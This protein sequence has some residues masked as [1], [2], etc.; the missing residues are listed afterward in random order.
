MSEVQTVPGE[1]Q[2]ALTGDQIRSAFLR[3]FEQRGH[4]VVP[5][6]S[7]VPQNDPTLL[8][9][10]AG[11]NQFKDVFLGKE[12]RDYKRATSSQKCVRAGGKHNDLENVGRTARHHTFF[13]MLG[14]F[15]FGDYFKKEAIALRVGAP[16]AGHGPA[17]GPPEGHDLQGRRRRAPRRGGAR[18]L[19]RARAAPTASSSWARRTTSGPWATPGPA[20]RARRSTSSRAT[21]LPC[22][23]VEAGRACLGVECECDRWLEVWNLVFMQFD[24]DAAGTLNPLPAACVDTGMGL[25]RITS[26]VQ[27]KLSNYDTDL[28]QPIIQA[29]APAG[30]HVLRGERRGRRLAARGGRPPARD[31]L[32]DRRRRDARQRGPRLRAAQDHAARDAPRQEAGPRGAVPA[33]ARPRVVVERMAGAYPEL[34]TQAAS[35]ARV[36]RA[37]EERFGSTLKQAMVEFGKTVEKLRRAGQGAVIP[38]ADAFRLYDTY[39]LPS[40]SWRS[41]PRTTS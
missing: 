10:N 8:F 23:E 30:G 14:N 3:Y 31:D 33:R 38:G 17:Q 13:E 2:K 19:A 36:V 41:W 20:G 40:T 9:A 39:G 6:S 12:K 15:S 5:S 34:R 22:A 29:V 21:T 18:L 24:R 11:M 26:V 4:R 32:P 37:E 7:L 25:E 1:K 28:F 16:D 35:V 27:G